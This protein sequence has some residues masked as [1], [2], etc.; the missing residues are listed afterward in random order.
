[1]SLCKSAIASTPALLERM[2]QVVSTGNGV[3]LRNGLDKY[4]TT[5][6]LMGAE[7]ISNGNGRLRIFYGSG[8]KAHNADFNRLVAPALGNLMKRFPQLELVIVGHLLPG[9]ELSE[10]RDR[11]AVHPYIADMNVYW[12]LLGA[13]DINL[14]V[15]EGGAVADCKSEIKWLEAAVLQIPSVVSGTITYRE[16][17]KDGVDGLIADTP[18]QWQEQLE[19]LIITPQLREAI[20]ARARAKALLAYDVSIGADILGNAFDTARKKSSA[21]QQPRLRI[22]ICNVFYSPQSYGGA[23]RVVEDNVRDFIERYQNLDVA[24]CCTNESHGLPGTLTLDNENGVPVYRI[25]VAQDAK[26][27]WTP[28]DDRNSAAFTR[29]LEHFRPDLIHFHCIQRLTGTIVE[30]AQNRGIPYIVS[31]HDGWWISENQFFV[32]DEGFMRLPG[33]DLLSDSSVAQVPLAALTRR[34]RLSSLLNGSKANLAVSAP[35]GTIYVDAG[36]KKVCVVENGVTPICAIEHSTRMDGRVGLGHIGGRSKHKGAALVEAVLRRNRYDNLHLTMIDGSLGTGEQIDT[37]WGTTPITLTGAYPQS[38]VAELYNRFDVLLAPS[39]WPES[40]GLVTREATAAGLWVVASNLGAVAEN[41]ED[42]GNGR[43][44]DVTTPRGL[45]A[46]L[47]EID[48]DPTRFSAKIPPANRRKK[49]TWR[50]TDQQ[51]AQLHSLYHEI[52][53]STLMSET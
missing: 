29:I 3:V 6:T 45:A 48:A 38:R 52:C 26:M 21:R 24:V 28:F 35:F 14:A 11:I 32:D 20:G 40:F 17:I 33:P 7:R 51:A 4:N 15:L 49:G 37:I 42:G 30:V 23:T 13:C 10:L 46:A 18:A 22:L 5:H 19:R 50:S 44:I 31:L 1:M 2:Q 25:T 43:I 34:Q 9:P 53:D 16:V 47:S 41:I 12:S 8:T 27:D 36:I 39:T